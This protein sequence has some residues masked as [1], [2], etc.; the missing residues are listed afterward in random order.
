M[1]A[2]SIYNMTDIFFIGQTGDPN[3]V[4]AVS[5]VFPVFMLSLALGNI[6]VIG[7]SSYIS[8]MLGLKNNEEVK[9]TSAVSF[10]LSL[11]AGLALT[12]VLLCFKMPMLSMIGSSEETIDHANGYYS[13]IALFMPFAVAGTLFSGIIRSEGA[14]GK[15]MTLQLFGIVLKI[16]LD[17]IFISVLGWGTKGAAW[18]TIAG[19]LASFI[20]GVWYFCQNNPYYQYIAGIINRIKKCCGKFSPLEFPR[21]SRICS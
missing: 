4:A 19:Q 9:K 15:V 20:Y 5:L 7:G 17:P 2:Q 13:I 16:V 14:T 8:R 3:M 21:G 1:L 10:Y 11:I 18:A 6:F 12:V